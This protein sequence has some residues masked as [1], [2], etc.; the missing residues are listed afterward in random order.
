MEYI[1]SLLNVFQLKDRRFVAGLANGLHIK[2][3]KSLTATTKH[4]YIGVK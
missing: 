2:Q 1:Q 3:Q 4:C